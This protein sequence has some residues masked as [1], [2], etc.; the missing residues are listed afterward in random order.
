MNPNLP[1]SNPTAKVGDDSTASDATEAV[2]TTLPRLLFVDDEPGILSAMKRV[3]RGAGYEIFTAGSGAEALAL[4][5]TQPVDLIISDMRM[6]EMDGAQLLEKVFSRWPEIKRILLTGYSDASATIA[7]INKG[8][9]WR[10]ISKPWDDAEL[11]L[12]VE[13]ALAHRQLLRENADLAKRIRQ[14]NEELKTLNASLEIKVSE[15]TAEL[16]QANVELHHSFLATVQVF[17]NLI[18]LREGKLAGHSKRVA[19]LARQIAERMGL[20]DA[21]QRVVLLAGLLHDIGKVGLPDK[22]LERPFNALTPLDKAE[23]MR[24]PEKG[25]RLLIGVPQLA[26]PAQIIRHHHECM[27]GSGYPDQLGGLMIP[28]GAR[29][30]AVANDYDALQMGSLALHA[31]KPSEAREAIIKQRGK[32]YDPTVVDAFVALLAE[33]EP[34][35][36]SETVV[37][38]PELKPGMLLTRDLLHHEGYLLLP[39]GRVLDV[40]MIAQLRQL[41]ET[42][43]KSIQVHIRR[44]S[45]PTTLREAQPT[46]Q[47]RTWKEVALKCTQLKEGMRLSRSLQ[48]RNGYLLLARGNQLTAAIIRQLR[49][50]ETVDGLPLIIHIHVDTK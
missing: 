45:G 25:Q 38:V 12:C 28:F 11:L 21:E 47:P 19:D 8:K 30:L 22:L 23:V 14:Q 43:S 49:D 50:I 18:E 36:E 33:A 5:E 32:R 26:E 40:S 16:R 6:P 15:R 39:K 13:Q 27:D 44:G 48:H 35:Q 34:K 24:H 3:F 10:Y 17:S 7:A 20:D 42:E 37:P 29:I 4:L 2:P 41:Q 31:H 46:A 1:D 9:I